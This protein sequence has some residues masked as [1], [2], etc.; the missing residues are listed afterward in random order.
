MLG[1]STDEINTS[2]YQFV[3]KGP[4][5]EDE[6]SWGVSY[7]GYCQHNGV[8]VKLYR[9]N[10]SSRF[11]DGTKFGFHLD[12]WNGFVNLYINGALVKTIWT[13]SKFLTTT[14]RPVVC[15]TAARTR[16]KI[17]YTNESEISLRYL[18]L[19]K[20]SNIYTL[21]DMLQIIRKSR[22]PDKI[23]LDYFW[24]FR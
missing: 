11:G 15:S 9:Q 18:A 14:T 5:G 23:L 17:R 2:Q 4:L 16:M 7:H 12:T 19:I 22:F 1:I 21:K 20:A 6:N 8:R 3:F 10:Q 24:L 13:S